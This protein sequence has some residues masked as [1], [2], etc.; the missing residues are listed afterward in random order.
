MSTAMTPTTIKIDDELKA[1]LA[2][3]AGARDRSA[4]WL[5]NEAIREF[6]NREE[7]RLAYRQQ[8]LATWEN[9]ERTGLH[10]TQQEVDQWLTD[11]ADGLDTEPPK[12]HV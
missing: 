2:K 1:R 6:V 8:A 4:N 7:L 12:C 9:Y 10:A 3:L 5:I 11:L